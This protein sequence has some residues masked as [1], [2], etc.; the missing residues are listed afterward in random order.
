MPLDK[1]GVSPAVTMGLEGCSTFSQPGDLFGGL[2]SAAGSMVIPMV[3]SL[4]GVLASIGW[5]LWGVTSLGRMMGVSSGRAMP[6]NTSSL[7]KERVALHLFL[8]L[9]CAPTKRHGLPSIGGLTFSTPN[10]RTWA[11]ATTFSH[12][13]SQISWQAKI[14]SGG[15][16]KL[17]W[18]RH[19]GAARAWWSFLTWQSSLTLFRNWKEAHTSCASFL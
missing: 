14:E 6:L 13:I 4:M 11:Y 16:K 19:G 10:W 7:E 18:Q 2:F 5:A 12:G 8:K 1:G 17:F 9:Y 15:G 3:S